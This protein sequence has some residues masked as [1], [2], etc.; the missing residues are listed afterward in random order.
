VKSPPGASKITGG[1]FQVL[2]ASML[3]PGSILLS[4]NVRL[5]CSGLSSHSSKLQATSRKMRSVVQ[6]SSR[7]DS[8]SSDK[9][10]NSE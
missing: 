3:G 10:Q 5:L 6:V 9:W 7:Q 1:I 4:W 8:F 2:M